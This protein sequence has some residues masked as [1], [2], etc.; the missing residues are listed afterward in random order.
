[1]LFEDERFEA[2]V[3]IFVTVPRFVGDVFCGTKLSITSV[4]VFEFSTSLLCFFLFF[5]VF[6]DTAIVGN[7]SS[8]LLKG[9]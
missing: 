1:M 5:A 6:D 3:L 2:T 9:D 7:F 8:A 4:D